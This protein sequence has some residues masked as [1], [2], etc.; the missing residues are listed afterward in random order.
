MWLLP[1]VGVGWAA[2]NLLGGYFFYD[3]WSMIGRVL[4]T[5]PIEGMTT[6]YN[7]HLWM[8]QDPI[9]RIQVFWFGVDDN[10][11]VRGVFMGALLLLHLSLAALLRASGVSPLS[12]MM[13]GGLL[14]YL[15]A[16]AEN[17]IWPV[18]VS[19][20]LAVAAGVA[21]AAIALRHGPAPASAPTP[22]AVAGVVVLTLLSVGIDSAIALMAA[23]LAACVTFLAWRGIVRFAGVPALAV[24][25]LWILFADRG[26]EFPADTA[27]RAAFAVRLVLHSAGGVFG[28]GQPGGAVVLIVTIA[29]IAFGLRQGSVDRRGRIMLAAGALSALIVAAALTIA[30]AG[31]VGLDFTNGN[32]YLH[33]VIIPATLA[34]A[35]AIAA[36]CRRAPPGAGPLLIVVAFFLGLVP[37]Q[38]HEVAFRRYNL[39]TREGVATTAAIIR[40][41]CPS[42]AAPNPDGRP[43][44]YVGPEIT[45]RLV[46]E[47]LDRGVLEA[48]PPRRL[49]TVVLGRICDRRPAGRD[50]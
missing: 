8:L 20:T 3:D 10:F 7:G 9:Y 40:G 36:T 18:Q 42:G 12:S 33:N 46:R 11:F 38:N 37:K 32:R 25:A 50:R 6:G 14:T 22:L 39:E 1:V 27:T 19:P 4:H 49:S 41:G 44:D 45:T 13:L 24:L 16:A 31:I 30:R 21:A 15:G 26:P 23:T 35:P 29:L 5:T 47:L 2:W 48:D 28:L 17:Y 43:L 34:A